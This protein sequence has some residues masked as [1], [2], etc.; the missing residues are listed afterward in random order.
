MGFRLRSRLVG[1]EFRGLQSGVSASS[2]K[3]WMNMVMEDPED[4]S[5]VSARV[6]ANMQ[7]DVYNREFRKG[8][9]LDCE[10]VGIAGDD[11]AYINLLCMPT[12]HVPV[13]SDDTDLEGLA[14]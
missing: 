4:C 2:G 12:V 5:Q 13:T 11:Y 7:S 3:A 14:Y 9:L 6:P 10:V 1:Y 8:D